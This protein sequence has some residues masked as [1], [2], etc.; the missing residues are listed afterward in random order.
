MSLFIKILLITIALLGI[1]KTK[2]T[3]MFFNSWKYINSEPTDEYVLLARTG[4]I[5]LL[6]IIIAS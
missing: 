6:V 5:I 3:L 1:F 2:K 4:Y